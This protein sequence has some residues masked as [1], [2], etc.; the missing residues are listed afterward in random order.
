MNA[1]F[2]L[3][4]INIEIDGEPR[5]RDL[6]LGDRLGYENPTD[7][8]QVIERNFDELE[9]YG[10]FPQVEEK[11]GGRG[12]PRKSYWLNEPQSLLICMF[13]KTDMAAEV[14]S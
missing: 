9:T 10:I 6:I 8:R 7:V 2:S 5:L 4:D 3:S 12:R 13:S 14:R 1:L 11:I